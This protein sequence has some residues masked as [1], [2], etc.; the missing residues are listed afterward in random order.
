MWEEPKKGDIIKLCGNHPHA[1]ET[2]EIIGFE[3]I[4][5]LNKPAM[6]VKLTTGQECG[7][8][9]FVFNIEETNLFQ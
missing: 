6:R 3:T 8:E 9:C 2:A 5:I 7:K 1:G 4:K